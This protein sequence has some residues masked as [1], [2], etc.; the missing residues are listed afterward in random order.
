MYFPGETVYYKNYIG[1]IRFALPRYKKEKNAYI[2]TLFS[3]RGFSQLDKLVFEDEL[4]SF[5]Q[6]SLL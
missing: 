6:I 4:C 2:I 1:Q 5:E 3:Y